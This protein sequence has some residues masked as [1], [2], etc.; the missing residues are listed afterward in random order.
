M[1]PESE[2]GAMRDI[3]GRATRELR[4]ARNPDTHTEL[5][6]GE[7]DLTAT[8]KGNTQN[9]VAVA[10]SYSKAERRSEEAA[11]MLERNERPADR[12]P[13]RSRQTQTSQETDQEPSVVMSASTPETA[14]MQETRQESPV[15]Q[16]TRAAQA[17][18]IQ[19]QVL[20]NLENRSMEF[21]MTLRPEELG[22]I[23]VKM[24]LQGGKLMIEIISSARVSE[25]LSRQ[26]EALAGSLRQNAPDDITSVQVVTEPRSFLG[27][28]D[29]AFNMNSQNSGQE[30]GEGHGKHNGNHSGQKE[31][32]SELEDAGVKLDASKL[33][34]YAI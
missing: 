28:T 11:V 32:S 16:T 7:Q 14:R 19:A 4:L 34:D 21:R 6:E 20:R 27:N 1:R 26:T 10:E 22:Q 31:F 15:P 12:I 33:L 17:E 29:N 8:L 5:P 25:I 13:A 23:D 24:A 30:R 2:E 3:I 9:V 18:Q